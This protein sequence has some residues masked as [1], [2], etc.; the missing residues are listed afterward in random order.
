MHPFRLVVIAVALTAA[1]CAPNLCERAAKASARAGGDCGPEFT[2]SLLGDACTTNL[3]ACSEADVQLLTTAVG[4]IEKLPVCSIVAKDAWKLSENVCLDP[5]AGLST[6]CLEAFFMGK[7]PNFDAG[8]PDA[9][10]QPIND[11]GS[12]LAL[13]GVVSDDTIALGWDQRQAA[14]VARWMLVQTDT[15]GDGREERDITPETVLALTISDAGERARRYHV[16]G[17]D[18]S[19]AVVWGTPFSTQP[20]EDAGVQC[21]VGGDCEEDKVCDLGQC[22]QQTCPFQMA[23]TCPDGYQCFM[24]GICRRTGDAGAYLG[25]ST[26]D[27]G[28]R[29]LPFSSN[30]VSLLPGPPR[31]SFFFEVGQVAARRPDIAG[32]DTARVFLAAEQEGQLIAHPSAARG[33]DYPIDALTSAGLDTTGSR[34]HVAWNPQGK[35]L[36]ACYIVGRGVRVQKSVDL[37]R[38]WGRAAVTFEPPLPDDGGIGETIRDCDIAPWGTGGALL[39]TAEDDAILVR[40]LSANLAEEF[41]GP[42]FRSNYADGGAEAVFAPSH[43]AVATR[44]STSTVHVTFTANRY[45]SGMVVDTEPYGVFREGQGSFSAPTRMTGFTPSAT[46]EDWTA[47]AIHPETGRVVGAFATVEPGGQSQTVYVSMFNP[48]ARQW[49]TGSHLNVFLVDQ[50]TSVVLPEKAPTA[51]W[52]A[53]SPQVAPLPRGRFAF[54]FVAGPRMNGIGDYR[55]YLVPFDP[56]RTAATVAAKGW[57]ELPVTRV[58]DLRV[59]D[60]RGSL[61]APQP[62]VSALAADGQVSVYGVFIPGT[63][64]AGDTEGAARFFSFP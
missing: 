58:S 14:T 34:V 63:G 11:G 27:A 6:P 47:V 8:E 3:G 15:L 64:L 50:N 52:F 21:R 49:G 35:A 57:W 25:G 55:Q 17:L 45:V 61:S 40:H 43:P 5:L 26:I 30:A 51:T 10:P 7:P 33:T 32:I 20:E 29:S 12:A 46:P 59:L 31:V 41:R 53:F 48:M 39:V 42:A 62:P 23:N 13:F 54:T 22:R 44:P 36:F 9:G 18:E 38:T 19:G 60:P 1:G 56:E 24:P 37:G 16:V 4:C 28:A 2:R